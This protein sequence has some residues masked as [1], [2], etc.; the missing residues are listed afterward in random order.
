MPRADLV[1]IIEALY[2]TDLD[3]RAWLAG[4]AAAT[5]AGL[6]IANVGAYALTY[7]ASDVND[8]TFPAFAATPS[9]DPGL[10]RLLEVDFV[11]FWRA[12][13]ALVEAVFRHVAYG[14]SRDLPT[15][16]TA[17]REAHDALARFGVHEV[18][19]LNGVN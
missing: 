16:A 14:P 4:V 15:A 11:E 7:D 10:A 8:T 3:E 18:L 13:P 2:A 19:G 17:L 9:T 6:R 1:S 5:G 12:R